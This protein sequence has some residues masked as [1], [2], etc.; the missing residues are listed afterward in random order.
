MRFRP[1]AIGLFSF[2]ILSSS[3]QIPIANAATYASG[4]PCEVVVSSSANLSYSLNSGARQC[5]YNFAYNA[6]SRTITLPSNLVS[7]VITLIGASG[8]RGGPRNDGSTTTYALSSSY[9]GQ[10]SGTIPSASSKQ[11]EI[12]TGGIGANGTNPTRDG[13][14]H[15]GAAGGITS[16]S[17]GGNGGIGGGQRGAYVN[18]YYPSGTGGGGGAATVAVINGTPIFAGG[19]GGTGGT[20]RKDLN[21]NWEGGAAY[22]NANSQASQFD[23]VA[24]G[25]NPSSDGD[26]S[27]GSNGGAGGAGG[28]GY[29]G[30]NGGIYGAPRCNAPKVFIQSTGGYPG[31]NGSTYPLQTTASSYVLSSSLATGLA[32]GVATIVITYKGTAT[33]T[34]SIPT[35]DLV[36]RQ[37]KVISVTSSVAGRITFTVAG[38]IVPGC[39]NKASSAANSYTV[40][41]SYLPSTHNLVIMT[42][43]FDPT[44]PDFI[45]TVPVSAQFQVANRT[46]PRVR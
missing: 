22:S 31:S 27:C 18:L 21:V 34:L 45:G 7:A 29:Q 32:G 8:G 3:F 15:S 4:T 11:I 13:A 26:T 40:T 39:K 2:A 43:T 46:G 25:D 36:Y 16:Y 19:G 35:G 37:A 33:A 44:D 6:T 1:T 42:A 23:G 10:Y 41:C 30:G 20:G 17:S 28:G 14:F 9:V 38:K 12:H 24:G 5:T